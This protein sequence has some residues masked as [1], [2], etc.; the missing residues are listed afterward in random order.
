MA[1]KAKQKSLVIVESPA[2]AKTIN[3]Y[4]GPDFE[5]KA[6]MG[7]VRDLP[8]KGINVDIEND[9]EPTYDISKGKKRT[10]TSLK[11]AAKK[12][13]TLFLATDLDREGEA[14]AWHLSEV[15]GFPKKDTY[16]VVFNAITRSAIEGAFAEPGRI[17]MDKVMA[18]QARRILDRIVGYQISPL[19]WKKVA[20]GLSAGRVQSVA[21]KIIVE[22]ERQIRQFEPVEYWLIPAVFTTD[23]ETDYS[24]KWQKFLDSAK[25]P[26][27]G[28]TIKEQNRWL[29]KHNALKA[30]LVTINGEKFEAN[31]GKRAKKILTDLKKSDFKVA[32][33]TTKRVTSK[34]SPPFITSTLQQAAANRLGFTAKKTMGVAQQLYEGIDM[35][36]MGALGLIT[37]MRTDSTH[38]SAEALDAARN[39][40]SRNIGPEYIPEKPNLF[41]SKKSAQQAHEAIR[42]TDPDLPPDEIGQFLSDEQFK[43]YDLIWRRFLACQMKPA[44]YDTTSVKVQGQTSLGPAIYRAS[45]RV[46]VFDGFTKLWQTNSNDQELPK[47][48]KGDSVA[49]VD[50]QA[51][52]NFTKP[53]ARYTEAS[54]VKELE[55]EGIGRPSTYASIISTIQ[56]RKYVEKIDRKFHATD[57]ADVVTDKLCEFFPNIMD[58]AFTRHMEDQLDKIEEQHID[59]VGVLKEFYAPFKESLAKATEEMKHAKAE[60][61]P[62]EYTCPKCK[63]PMVY[64]FGKNGRFL[65]CSAYPDC[66]FAAPCDKDGKLLEEKES[67]HKCPKCEQ[68][69]IQKHG[70][71]GPFLGCSGYPDCKTILG[72]DK[73][74]N[75]LPPKP[76]P[77]PTGIKCYKCKTGELVVRQSKKGPFIGCN[78]FPKCRTIISMKQVDN[79]KKLQAEGKW[80]PKTWEEAD[81]MLGRKTAKTKKSTKKATAKAK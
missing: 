56:D 13:G 74:G 64:R 26:E 53:P 49:A 45:G 48:E 76:P 73:E 51:K 75:I 67:E 66:K 33:L 12:C 16:R 17:D 69:M 54:L 21:V 19:L 79:L 27:K 39:Y 44:Q 5:V 59:W 78:K 65:S 81:E 52:Q 62:S 61:T 10:V 15:L 80:P 18:Q 31:D 77:E 24:D 50:V 37:Y 72:I 68:P 20:W 32:D 1:K 29:T 46:Q 38:L 7:H 25:D 34:P 43:L 22:R 42:P 55:K 30:D 8:S 11:A 9:F 57:V 58:I 40:I 71:F 41:A 28:R 47:M 2:K 14:I 23:L 63:Q 60:T 35:G 70:R 6:S 4:L 36:S 3:K